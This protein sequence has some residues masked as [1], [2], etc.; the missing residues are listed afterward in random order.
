MS[1][2]VL[3]LFLAAART[4]AQGY[5]SFAKWCS[6]GTVS[7]GFTVQPFRYTVAGASFVPGDFNGDRLTDVLV[8]RESDGLFAKW[9]STDPGACL[10]DFFYRDVRYTLPNAQVYIGDF[11]GD[12]LSDV[13]IYRPSDG[14]FA[15]WYA[16]P[17]IE[18][19]LAP[20]FVYQEVRVT[21]PNAE[22]YLG[23]F[24]GDGLTDVF[25]YR[26][27]D[28]AFAKWYS[29]A[30]IG[31]AFLYQELRYGPTNATIVTGDFNGDGLTDVLLYQPAYGSGGRFQKWYS[32][33]G[34]GPDFDRMAARTTIGNATVV[35]GD[36]NG[37]G[38]TDVFIYRPLD[39]VFAKWYSSDY[40]PDFLYQD[41]RSTYRF[42]RIFTGDFDGDGRTD[43]LIA[44]PIQP[45]LPDYWDYEKWYSQPEIVPDFNRQRVSFVGPVYFKT[46]VMGQFNGGV[47]TDVLEVNRF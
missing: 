41:F 21:I 26:R 34:I 36:F 4:Y 6:D 43:L 19:L 16:H 25:I 35:T 44:T 30:D 24:N 27:S 23:D 14:L 10:P 7:P 47:A 13:F 28:G 37:D 15:K 11:N 1:K 40:G 29:T 32:T 17:Y 20:D 2:V 45:L 42:S 18:A 8:Y 31:P 39:G 3:F 5:A 38:L 9:Y 22:I 12:G 46:F 33:P